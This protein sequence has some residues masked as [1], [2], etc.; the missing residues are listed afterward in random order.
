[1]TAINETATALLLALENEF[2]TTSISSEE[3][4]KL[5]QENETLAL[6]REQLTI[7]MN[8]LNDR[9]VIINNKLDDNKMKQ[10]DL[11]T[12]NPIDAV[13]KVIRNPK[14]K[15]K[16]LPIY[17]EILPSLYE[18]ETKRKIKKVKKK[19]EQEKIE[20]TAQ[21]TTKSKSKKKKIPKQNDTKYTGD[22]LTDIE[23]YKYQADGNYPPYTFKRGGA[24]Q[25]YYE[26]HSCYLRC[27]Y[28]CVEF[29]R[30]TIDKAISHMSKCKKNPETNKKYADN[31]I[32]PNIKEYYKKEWSRLKEEEKEKEEKNSDAEEEVE[33][34]EQVAVEYKKLEG[35]EKIVDFN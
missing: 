12:F 34:V 15:K 11:T 35:A 7:Q 19:A 1:M 32:C 16:D 29:P 23:K 25:D 31:P 3:Y 28:N 17:L 6:E 33:E 4:I 20:L 8:E 13:V 27:P 24:F 30:T 18:A 26:Y 10:I 21:L 22:N 2:K 14:T 5:E 9:Q